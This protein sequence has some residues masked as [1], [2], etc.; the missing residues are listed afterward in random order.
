MEVIW[1]NIFHLC[2][3][4]FALFLSLK[5]PEEFNI[6]RDNSAFTELVC[7]WKLVSKDTFEKLI[8]KDGVT[9]YPVS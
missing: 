2:E 5:L 1:K 3:D 9:P 8:Q 4:F 7:P 6:Y